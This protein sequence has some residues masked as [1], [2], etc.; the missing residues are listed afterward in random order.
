M[1][2]VSGKRLAFAATVLAATALLSGV[3]T[4]QAVDQAVERECA[5]VSDSL[6]DGPISGETTTAGETDCLRLLT[7]YGARIVLFD[8]VD[9][10]QDADIVVRDAND[11]YQCS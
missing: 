2:L 11:V 3:D 9:V 8:R 7:P 10:G 4:A 5:V 1:L 6:A